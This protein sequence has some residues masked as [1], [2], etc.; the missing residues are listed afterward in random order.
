[1]SERIGKGI[2]FPVVLVK[3]KPV[4]ETG[5]PL[6]MSS[7]KMILGWP[8]R[9][10]FFL[11][12]FGSRLEELLEEPN[13]EFLINMAEFFIFSAIRRWEPRVKVLDTRVL[14][15]SYEALDVLITYRIIETGTTES[16]VFP[17]YRYRLT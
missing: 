11:A 13:D 16:F 10:R 4:I 7:I 3:G 5:N 2:V 15:Q 17:F 8:Y 12:I 14:K 6:I 1:M 9:D